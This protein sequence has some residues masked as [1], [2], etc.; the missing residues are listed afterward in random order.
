LGPDV[1]SRL[2]TFLVPFLFFV[3]TAFDEILFLM[4]KCLAVMHEVAGGNGTMGIRLR[5]F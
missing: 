4:Q 2:L 3:T 1:N 5:E